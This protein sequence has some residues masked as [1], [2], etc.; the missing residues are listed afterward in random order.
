MLLCTPSNLPIPLERVVLRM[1]SKFSMSVQIW[2][3]PPPSQV[4]TSGCAPMAICPNAENHAFPIRNAYQ[5][6]SFVDKISKSVAQ[7]LWA[8]PRPPTGGQFWVCTHGTLHHALNH[9][10]PLRNAYQVG[11]FVDKIS[12]SALGHLSQARPQPP[13]LCAGCQGHETSG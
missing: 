7:G 10:F 3:P 1:K 6:G 8:P 13:N 4:A 5:V 9:A 12:K 2:P 11:S